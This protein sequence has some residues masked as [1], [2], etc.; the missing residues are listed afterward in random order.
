MPLIFE[1]DPRKART[2]LA[3]HRVA[4]EDPATIFGDAL[5][6]TIPDPEHS[7]T[8]EGY[9]TTGRAFTGKC[10]LSCIQTGVIIFVSSVQE[11]PADESASSMKKTSNKFNRELMREEYDFSHGVRGKYARRYAQGTNVVVLEPDV[12]RVFSDSKSVNILLRKII[13]QRAS[14]A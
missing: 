3:K 14:V 2:N 5:S 7:R 4:F 12:A 10:S 8:E 1:W 11:R 13:R 9:I 6:F